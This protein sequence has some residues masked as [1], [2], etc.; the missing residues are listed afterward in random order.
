MHCYGICM[1]YV[2]LF[3]NALSANSK[4]EF[5]IPMASSEIIF[6]KSILHKYVDKYAYTHM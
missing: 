1:E 3:Q 6:W 5:A 4:I 2:A